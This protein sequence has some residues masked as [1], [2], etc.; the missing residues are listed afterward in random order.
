MGST[1]SGHRVAYDRVWGAFLLATAMAPV[2]ADSWAWS[3]DGDPLLNAWVLGGTAMG[4]L[5]VVFGF[6]GIRSRLRHAI[7]FFGGCALVAM[8]LLVPRLWDRF[9]TVNPARL[10]L[11]DVGDTGWV[12]LIAL[13]AVYAGA[14]VRVAR[15]SQFLGMA[16]G[17][18]GALVA[19]I[20]ACLPEP[21]GGSGYA[22]EKILVFRNLGER[23]KELLPTMLGAAGVTC[24]VLNMVRNPA[25]VTLARLSRLLVVGALLVT[26]MLPFDPVVAWGAMRFFAPL[27]LAIDAA[28]AF[29]AI[30]ITRTQD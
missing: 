17:T 16:L 12:M 11:A 9:P 6:S 4:A 25:E 3:V 27:F 29:T 13:G 22:S 14:G 7:N 28:I 1:K 10:P 30:S 8:P 24:S 26:L 5:A 21:V 2:A 19:T 23:W 20:F 18:P 15:P